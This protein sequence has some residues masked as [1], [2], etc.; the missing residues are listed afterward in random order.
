MNV[1]MCLILPVRIRI[2]TEILV[3]TLLTEGDVARVTQVTGGDE[4]ARQ[5]KPKEVAGF[6]LESGVRVSFLLKHWGKFFFPLTGSYTVISSGY[7][8]CLLLSPRQNGY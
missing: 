1:A 7:S 8:G 6:S 3:R 4:G 2:C 5:V